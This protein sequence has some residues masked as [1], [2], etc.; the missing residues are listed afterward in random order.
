[1]VKLREAGAILLIIGV[2]VIGLVE[3]SP[4]GGDQEIFDTCMRERGRLTL[5]FVDKQCA[6]AAGH[7]PETT[8]EM[9]ARVMREI[10]ATKTWPMVPGPWRIGELPVFCVPAPTG[11]YR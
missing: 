10:R 4:V 5:A 8:A 9:C 11:L 6:E 2:T 1:M 3:P 7:R